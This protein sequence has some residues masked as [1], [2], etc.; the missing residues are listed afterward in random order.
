MTWSARASGDGGIISVSSAVPVDAVAAVE[1]DVS[2]SARA[3]RAQFSR[4]ASPQGFGV[5]RD[6]SFIT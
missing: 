2:A 3:G 4:E 6:F 5:I 1:A